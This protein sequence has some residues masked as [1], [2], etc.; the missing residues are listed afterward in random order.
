[1]RRKLV[2][3]WQNA[4]ATVHPAPVFVLGNQKSGT[5]AVAGLLAEHTGLVGRLDLHW[6]H[7]P[8]RIARYAS[9][10]LSVAQVVRKNRHFF[11]ADV[12]KEPFFT[13][14]FE[15]LRAAFPAARFVW[16]VRDPRDN[17]RSIL[18]RLQVRGDQDALTAPQWQELS[19]AWREVIENRFL[20]IGD[21]T[22]I[23]K[24]AQRWRLAARAC[25]QHQDAVL[26]IRYEDF[27][28]DKLGSIQ[29]LASAL[30]L[31]ARHDITSRL[32]HAFQPPGK[33]DVDWLAFFGERNLERIHAIGSA[34]MREL[35]YDPARREPV[36][37]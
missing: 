25:L 15:E 31:P 32:D 2:R 17:L 29:R 7:R 9:G 35:G 21:D 1:M 26:A 37:R 19:P 28:G 13:F 18:D 4:T 27:A 11:S 23:G 36:A 33:R 3:L 24:L 34:E 30:D 6:L 20:G 16:V 10:R 14:W 12:I 8:R 22:Y 5:T